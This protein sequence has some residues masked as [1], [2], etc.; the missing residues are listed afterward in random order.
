MGVSVN[1]PVAADTALGFH[2]LP[3]VQPDGIL[4][5]F[6]EYTCD[7]R[8]GKVNLGI[9]MYY[10]EVGQVP[11]MRAVMEAEAV[12]QR[13]PKPWV[14]GPVEGSAAFALQVETLLFGADTAL[15][16]RC[17]LMQTLGG[18][19]A[20]SLG[21]QLL[22]AELE[23]PLVAL[24]TPTWPNHHP[25][26]S[27]AG[28]A[29]APYRYFDA[30]TGGLDFAGMLED[31][32]RLP[33]ASVVVLHGCCH[34]PTGVDLDTAQ[35]AQVADVMQARG[36]IPFLDLAYVG[37]AD[38]LEADLAPVR[39]LAARGMNFL[40][41]LSFSK[42]MS[43]YGER[44]GA[45]VVVAADAAGA[46]RAAGFARLVARSSYSMP[47]THGAALVSGILGQAP[48]RA[49][50]QQELEEMRLRIVAM[51]KALVARLHANANANANAEAGGAAG[52]L[53]GRFDHLLQQRGLFS[54]SRLTPVQVA[55]LKRDYAI[56]A[57]PDGRL[58]MAALTDDCVNRVAD[59]IAAVT[60]ADASHG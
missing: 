58:C 17:T 53:A 55:L 27:R 51:R 32:E 10:N 20:L 42:S 25:V 12:L 41:A 44:V 46:A 22:Q 13:T 5:S 45:L 29:R 6:E 8:D 48:L 2:L 19:G 9:G 60:G 26:F 7:P 54:Y 38:G 49:M 15:H 59:A 11:L 24:S 47:P 18:T 37:F 57:V 52:A 3:P 1:Q 56:Y 36:L 35:W 14:Y 33:P 43:L 28:F 21:A 50:W 39:M 4:R 40:L 23:T 30:A 31:I 16:P 34:N